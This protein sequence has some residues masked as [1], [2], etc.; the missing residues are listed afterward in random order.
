MNEVIAAII[1]GVLGFLTG[2]GGFYFAN[3]YLEEKKQ[4]IS[5]S[6]KP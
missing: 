4:D 5:T 2:T 6:A 1:T 3:R